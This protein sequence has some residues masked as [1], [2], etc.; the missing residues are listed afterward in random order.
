MMVYFHTYTSILLNNMFIL[1]LFVGNNKRHRLKK[2][3]LNHIG[4]DCREKDEKVKE[5]HLYML[6]LYWT[7]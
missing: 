2:A 3:L 1:V 5:K 7:Y 4:K 6:D